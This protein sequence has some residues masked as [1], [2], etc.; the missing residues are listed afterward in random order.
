MAKVVLITGASAGIGTAAALKLAEK[1]YDLILTA[2]R[3]DRLED[4]AK[5]CRDKG[6]KQVLVKKLDVRDLKSVEA[7]FADDDVKAMLSRLEVLVNNAGLAKGVDRMDKAKIED[8]E[9][10]VETNVLGLMYMTRFALPYIK[11]TKG[12]IVNIGSVA[13]RWS[14]PGGGVYCS[15][16][17]AVRAFTEGL[18]MDLLGTRVRVTNIAPG[19]A[20]TEFTIT[21]L[22]SVDLAKKVYENFT[23]LTP[24][25]IAECIEWSISRPK[26]VNVQEM[27]I[28]PTDQ[29]GVSHLYRET[30]APAAT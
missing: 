6:A 2:R 28:Y 10:M 7:L 27:I 17:A 26:H 30:G 19:M 13:G 21:R 29:A 25:D 3:E 5:A 20:E 23:A 24:E 1:G 15:T 8:W 9:M 12:H 18:R 22:Q 4:V 16:K 14:Y 11:E